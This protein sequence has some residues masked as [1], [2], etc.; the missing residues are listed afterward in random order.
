MS[1]ISIITSLRLGALRAI[2]PRHGKTFLA[3]YSLLNN[4]G[5]KEPIKIISSMIISQSLLLLILGIVKPIYFLNQKKIQLISAIIII[6]F[7]FCYQFLAFKH[8]H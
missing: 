2:E 4:I 5:K 6:L 7:G 1:T 3:S 8:T